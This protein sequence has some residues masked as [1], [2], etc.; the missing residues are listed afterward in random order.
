MRTLKLSIVAI[1]L[2][3]TISLSANNSASSD[4]PIN[5]NVSELK[6]DVKSNL[7]NWYPFENI[8]PG[9]KQDLIVHYTVNEQNKVQVLLVKSSED[10]LKKQVFSTFESHPVEASPELQGEVFAIKV[11]LEAL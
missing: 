9:E 1:F 4:E 7:T 5:T 6:N 3:S 8:E 10:K 11:Q 2:A